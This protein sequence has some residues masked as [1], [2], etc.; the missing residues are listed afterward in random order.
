[1]AVQTEPDGCDDLPHMAGEIEITP[2]M[3]TAGIDAYCLFS[4]EDPGEWIIES[5]YRAMAAV[6][7]DRERGQTPRS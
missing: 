7:S 5:V 2:E 3:M 4:S 1:M 6:K